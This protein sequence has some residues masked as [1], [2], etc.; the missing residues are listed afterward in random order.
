MDIEIEIEIN[1]QLQLKNCES[2][3][4]FATAAMSP[5]EPKRNIDGCSNQFTDNFYQYGQ[6]PSCSLGTNCGSKCVR[7]INTGLNAIKSFSSV[8]C[9][10]SGQEV[11][12][13][14]KFDSEEIAKA[15]ASVMRSLQFY[16]LFLLATY[17]NFFKNFFIISL[18]ISFMK[19]T[20]KLIANFNEKL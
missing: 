2:P 7:F 13:C 11:F 17:L 15:S 5:F 9:T 20:S 18:P 12:V 10:A 8:I 14:R 4:G 6:R 16:K 3:K 1:L 19:L